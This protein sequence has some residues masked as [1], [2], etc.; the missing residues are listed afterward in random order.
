MLICSACVAE[1][2]AR[3]LVRRRG[4]TERGGKRNVDSRDSRERGLVNAPP[5]HRHHHHHSITLHLASHQPPRR[6]FVLIFGVLPVPFSSRCP[7]THAVYPITPSS[8][9]LFSSPLSPPFTY[10]AFVSASLSS[11]SN[12]PLPIFSRTRSLLLSRASFS[13]PLLVLF[14]F[15]SLSHLSPITP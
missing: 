6:P 12:T 8:Y 7:I 2:E 10:Q 13:I 15:P 9:T 3:S 14:S 5:R 1:Q 11:P 4:A